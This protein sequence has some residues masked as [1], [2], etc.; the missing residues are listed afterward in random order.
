MD[1]VTRCEQLLGIADPDLL[2]LFEDWL[3][4]MEAEA[5]ALLEEHGPLNDHELAE[6]LGLSRRGAA[7]LLSKIK[8]QEANSTKSK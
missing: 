2:A 5:M 3:E 8:R 7:F 4:E 6:K 1:K